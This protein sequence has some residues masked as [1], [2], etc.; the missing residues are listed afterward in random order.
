MVKARIIIIAIIA[1]VAV[2]YIAGA[3]LGSMLGA[4][5]SVGEFKE[6]W[7]LTPEYVDSDLCEGSRPCLAQP[8]DQQHNALV[9]L[10][11]AA[12]AETQQ[13]SYNDAALV[14]RIEEVVREFTGYDVTAEQLCEQPGALLVYR[15]YA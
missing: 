14:E 10:L 1:V 8:E 3:V 7:K 11:L 2:L 12:C 9:T 4:C 15:S 6:C 5:A 13:A